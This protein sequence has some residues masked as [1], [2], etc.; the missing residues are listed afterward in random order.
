MYPFL[1]AVYEDDPFLSS[2][3]NHYLVVIAQH[4]Y[5]HYDTGWMC[6]DDLPNGSVM[7]PDVDIRKETHKFD[8]EHAAHAFI[9]SWWAEQHHLVE[10]D[11]HAF[12]EHE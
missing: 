8:S 9:R 1:F 6:A 5:T 7:V 3:P 4:D 11:A 2:D 10:T 12:K